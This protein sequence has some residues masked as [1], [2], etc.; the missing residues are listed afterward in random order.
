MFCYV[1]GEFP[2]YAL[3]AYGGCRYEAPLIFNLHT[4]WKWMV[5]GVLF[6]YFQYDGGWAQNRSGRFGKEK[7][8][9]PLPGIE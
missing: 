5:L 7:D 2:V 6:R 8:L 4:R 9:L 3:M 1:K